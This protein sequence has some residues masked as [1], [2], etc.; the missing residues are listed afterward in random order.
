MTTSTAVT[1]YAAEP[2][3][4]RIKYAQVLARASLIPKSL[5]DS[6]RNDENGR[7]VMGG[8]SV[9][10]V[11]LVMEHGAM[12]GLHP[13]AAIN[14]IYIIEGKASMSAN[15]M[16]AVVRAK[17]FKLRVVTE[18]DWGPTF[19]ATASIV[20]PDDPDFTYSVTWTEAKA[21]RADLTGKD[22]WRKYPE[23]M[24]K[25]RAISEVIREGATDALNGLVYSPEELG[26]KVNESGDYETEDVGELHPEALAPA[27]PSAKPAARKQATN[28]TQG[29]RKP[30]AAEPAPTPEPAQPAAP[31]EAA[32]D[33]Q[34]APGT[35]AAYHHRA[36]PGETVEAW[37]AREAAEAVDDQASQSETHEE[38]ADD[39]RAA[40][41]VDDELPATNAAGEI[42]DAELVEDDAMDAA[43]LEWEA[44]EKA[45]MTAEREAH[46]AKLARI[47]ADVDSGI[48]AENAA[49]NA[50]KSWA[51]RI[52][53]AATVE[54]CR[55]IW[56]GADDA[57]ELDTE[58]RK[59]IMDQKANIEKL[60]A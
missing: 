32:P 48:A 9:G 15:L 17:G 43:Q 44:A 37:Q 25:A 22:N 27:A 28:G 52:A 29:T 1:P 5:W 24:A 51:E 39:D 14:G 54:E 3:D 19:K 60:A 42:I 21:K 18:G 16:S 50:P 38:P 34:E 41:L 4:E 40:V 31:A 46:Q 57:R 30:K 53:A 13:M 35:P 11:L 8:P 26:A 47:A 33:A 55:L 23:A 7:L 49:H 10:N 59:L 58:L 12:L 56:N 45:R 20:R 2:L 6:N 36:K